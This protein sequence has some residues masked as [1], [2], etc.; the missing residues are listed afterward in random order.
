[1]ADDF[2]N[3]ACYGA[4]TAAAKAVGGELSDREL[5]AAYRAAREE[6]EKLRAAGITDN[7]EDRIKAR[8]EDIAERTKI[9]AALQKRHTALNILARDRLDQTIKAFKAAGLSPRDSILAI[10]EGSQQGVEGARDSVFA[11]RLG[12]EARYVGA[13]MSEIQKDRPYLVHALAD[14]RLSDDVFREM[15]EI[16]EGGQ[17]GITGNEDAKYLAGVFAKHLEASRTELNKFGASIGKLDGWAGAQVHDDLKMIQAGKDAWISRTAPL[18]DLNRTFPD[19]SSPE[20]V[21][22]ILGDIYDTIITG[23]PNKATAKEKGQ[24]VN[25]ANL[26]KSLGKTR[27][28]HFKDAENAIAYR[29]VFGY[30][31]SIYGIMAHQ[32]R[33][34]SMA[35]QMDVFGPNP[36]IMFNSLVEAE[37]RKLRDDPNLDPEAK[38]KAIQK[39]TTDAGPLKGAFDVMSGIISRP[40]NVKAAKIGSDIR[41]VQSMAKLGAAVLTAMP[42][43]VV[44]AAQAAMFRGSGFWNGMVHQMDGIFRGRPKGEQAEIAYLFGEG[45]DS[46]VGEIISHGL[47]NDG[48]VG[49]MSKLTE[50]FFKWSGLNWWTDVGR[51]VVGRTVAA[52]IGMRAE[53]EFKDLPANFAHVLGLHGIDETRWNAIRRA[54]KREINGQSYITPDAIQDL[55]DEAVAPLVADRLATAK[56]DAR[57]AEIL[58]DGRRELQLALLRYV[59]DETNYAIVETD[60]ASRR[61]TSWGQRPGTFAGEAA[62]FIMQFKGFPVA[63]SQRILGRA[64]FGGRGATKYERIMNNAPHIGALIA[65]LTV[66]GYMAMTMKDA[67][68]GYWPP[69]NPMDPK[70][71]VAALT[72]GGALGIY[73]DFLF[74]QNNRFGSGAFETFS[75]PFI[76]TLSDMLKIPMKARD[77]AIEGKTPQLA[78]DVLNLALQ[79]TPYINLSYVRPALD[80]L[81]LNALRNW[82]SPGYTNRMQRQRLK[83]YGQRPLLPATL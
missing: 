59:A 21:K 7:V 58:N 73:G 52:E 38:V 72:Q 31:N 66:A 70:V 12:Y 34:A 18:L 68:K 35:A 78:G 17:P 69:R 42:T 32:R 75:G 71:I 83:D 48:P 76:G 45:F 44:G 27:V 4:A 49:K 1:M 9:A 77:A 11:S 24:R 50:Q 26:A 41:A 55:P 79:N 5:A 74:G 46:M 36:E 6:R 8:A 40:G 57:K 19:A 56:T 65:G 28:L 2:K 81:F 3:S 61:I 39:L 47:A 67:V 23:V 82:A 25:P 64:L 63:F 10:M 14:K 60:A 33:A 51:S 13:M 29:D 16:R 37:K 54:S 30:G 53:N 43:D 80:V 22:Q 20:E 15:G 62:R